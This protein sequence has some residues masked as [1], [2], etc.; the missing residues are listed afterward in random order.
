M[1][2]PLF[3]TVFT[4]EH[5]KT[6]TAA[7]RRA[8]T[9]SDLVGLIQKHVTDPA[10]H[11]SLTRVVGKKGDKLL[12]PR[13]ATALTAKVLGFAN[14]HHMAAAQFFSRKSTEGGKGVNQKWDLHEFLHRHQGGVTPLS[15]AVPS[16]YFPTV[17]DMIT[18]GNLHDILARHDQRIIYQRCSK[19]NVS[20]KEIDQAAHRVMAPGS[21]SGV[22]MYCHPDLIDVE[23]TRLTPREDE[24]KTLAHIKSLLSHFKTGELPSDSEHPEF[25]MN[26]T[27]ETYCCVISKE[28]LSTWRGRALKLLDLALMPL[29]V[30]DFFLVKSCDAIWMINEDNP[31]VFTFPLPSA[32]EEDTMQFTVDTVAGVAMITSLATQRVITCA[33]LMLPDSTPESSRHSMAEDSL[34]EGLL[35]PGLLTWLTGNNTGRSSQ[36]MVSTLL[37]LTNPECGYAHPH[38]CGD[39]YRC[40]QAL[41]RS[42]GLRQRLS[43]MSTVS[44]TWAHLVKYWPEIVANRDHPK[45][46]IRIINGGVPAKFV[47]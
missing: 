28:T 12:S 14:E 45:E 33:C 40:E 24:R 31:G 44:P 3:H 29:Y 17:L 7:L 42:P 20:Y 35:T 10:I 1:T 21:C 16:G 11:D 15:L 46:A 4:A 9:L 22:A 36:F 6:L 18:A 32:V 47:R 23:S 25:N 8:L 43:M 2:T 5:A 30:D 38:D 26:V 39:F 27:D 37:G 34:P 19:Q 13:M 41:S